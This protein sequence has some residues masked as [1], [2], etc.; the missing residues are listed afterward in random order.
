VQRQ[1]PVAGTACAC[2]TECFT[3]GSRIRPL[4]VTQAVG[5]VQ[6]L[7]PVKEGRPLGHSCRRDMFE[8]HQMRFQC[9]PRGPDGRIAG[10][11]GARQAA[12]QTS[13]KHTRRKPPRVATGLEWLQLAPLS[14]SATVSAQQPLCLQFCRGR[15]PRLSDQHQPWDPCADRS[16]KR[17]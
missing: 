10:N 16:R 6:C 14:P 11:K 17:K 3:P 1:G 8:R 7:K 13:A 5:M 12:E 15:A 9:S 4:Y 2:E